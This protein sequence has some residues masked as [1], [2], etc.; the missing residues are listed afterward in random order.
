MSPLQITRETLENLSRAI[1]E[2]AGRTPI[3]R[4][5]IETQRKHVEAAASGSV[6]D[7]AFGAL[8][9]AANDLVAALALIDGREGP[10]RA[11]DGLDA[12]A[13]IRRA[14]DTVARAALSIPIVDGGLL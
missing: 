12:P 14:G 10:T 13:L 6:P 5:L 4:R 1:R 2:A 7:V 11:S 9:D 3:P 8:W